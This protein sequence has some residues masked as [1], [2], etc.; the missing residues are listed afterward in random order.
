MNY[1]NLEQINNIYDDINKKN[2]K[3][4]EDRI[5]LIYDKHKDLKGSKSK[6]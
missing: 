5:S 2:E 4:Y 6:C 1:N 3:E